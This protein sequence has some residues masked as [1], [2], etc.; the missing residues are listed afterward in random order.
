MKS[1]P[2]GAKQ[3]LRIVVQ[4]LPEHCVYRLIAYADAEVYRPLEFRSH[5]AVTG[6]LR[7]L[8]RDIDEGVPPGE[9]SAGSQIVFSADV[10]LTESQLKDAGLTRKC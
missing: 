3:V 9:A 7:R 10:E 6:F 8:G 2:P 4:F 5:A 1:V